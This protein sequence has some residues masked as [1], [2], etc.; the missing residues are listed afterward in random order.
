LLL[1]WASP[2]ARVVA[3]GFAAASLVG[4]SPCW[5]TASCTGAPHVTIAGRLFDET[6]LTPVRAARIDFVRTGGVALARDSVRATTDANGN[7]LLV[8]QAGAEGTVTAEMVVRN[9]AGEPGTGL[10]YRVLDLAFPTLRVPGDAHVLPPWS[11][12]PSLP[13]VGQ[14]VLAGVDP[15]A[16]TGVQV[17]FRRTSGVAVQGNDVFRTVTG[18]SGIF[19]LFDR[20]VQPLD[21]GDVIGDLFVDYQG[22]V[23]RDFRVRATAEFRREVRLRIVDLGVAG[24]GSP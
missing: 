6:T 19:P 16:L 22:I 8:V 14:L 23:I 24:G 2:A 11:T 7:F 18:A 4:C 12:V 5:G 10:E 17:E 20:L 21:A 1:T 13:D 15:A 3:V 9:P